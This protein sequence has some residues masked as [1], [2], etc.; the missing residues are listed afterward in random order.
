M[1]ANKT[2][3]FLIAWSVGTAVGARAADPAK[4]AS[5]LDFEGDVIAGERRRPDIFLQTSAKNLSLDSIVY[6]RNDFN[7]FQVVDKTRRPQYVPA[8]RRR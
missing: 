2:K 1:R 8:R 6:L 5:T 3:I 4:A 7:D